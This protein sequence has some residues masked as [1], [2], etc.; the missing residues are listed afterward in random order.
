[1][2]KVKICGLTC[3]EDTLAAVEAGADALGFV[4]DEG[5]HRVTPE[6]AR[7]IIA[8]LPP[9]VNVVGVFVNEDAAVVHQIADF[10]RLDTLQFQGDEPPGYCAGFGRRVIKGFRVK[11]AASLARL[12][13]YDVAA[14]LLDSYVTGQSGGT[15]RTF[16]WELVRELEA[17]RPVILAGGLTPA[18]VARAIAVVQPYAVDVS[19]GVENGSG[20]KDPQK[21]ADFVRQARQAAEHCRMS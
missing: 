10:C 16:D 15:G 2:I 4:F 1:M 6:Q 9:F 7:A 11:D 3:I 5:R 13:A 21:M 12:E 18:N 20:R 8:A 14:Y 17:S 19:S